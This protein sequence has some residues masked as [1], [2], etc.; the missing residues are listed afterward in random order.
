MVLL[1]VLKHR[2]V[3]AAVRNVENLSFDRLARAGVVFLLGGT[4]FDIPG[5]VES[6]KQSDKL[7]FIDIDLIKGV[8]RDRVG[9]HYLATESR[10]HGIITTKSN[11]VT[12][13]KKEGLCT[14]QRVFALDSESLAGGLNVVSQSKP[15][16]IE[17]LPGLVVPKVMEA[18]RRRTSIPII[19][20]GLITEEREVEEILG[21]G[22]VGISTTSYHL[23]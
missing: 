20:G 23:L 12:S 13:G 10:V 19:A 4:I 11:L 3:I 22:A 16:A 21:S 17:I 6:A 18:I 5:I 7:V 14:I 1:K 8:G 9:V 2:P 15:D